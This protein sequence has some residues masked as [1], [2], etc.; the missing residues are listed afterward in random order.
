MITY[1]NLTNKELSEARRHINAARAI[2]R[3]ANFGTTRMS[4]TPRVVEH[5][6]G[7]LADAVRRSY[8]YKSN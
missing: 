3:R 1:A 5:E 8:P 2:L 4:G 7:V 6:L